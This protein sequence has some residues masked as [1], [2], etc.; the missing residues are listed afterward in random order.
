MQS[1]AEHHLQQRIE[2]ETRQMSIEST[3]AT[4]NACFPNTDVNSLKPAIESIANLNRLKC[5]NLTASNA[6]IFTAFREHLEV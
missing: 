1:M 3:L 2:Q 6:D 5:L 4:L